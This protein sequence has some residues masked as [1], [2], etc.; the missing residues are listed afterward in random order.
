M[1]SRVYMLDTNTCS[2]IIR[3]RPEYLLDTL[4]ERVASGHQ[5][6]VSAITYAELAFGAIN[7]K[8]SPKMP[9][10]VAEFVDRLDAVLPWDKDA[11]AASAAI[12]KNW[13]PK[14]RRSAITTR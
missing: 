3:K 10:I 4:Q 7:K 14:E 5:I 11:V 9:G 8:A 13:N 6:V 2:F 1:E 12:K